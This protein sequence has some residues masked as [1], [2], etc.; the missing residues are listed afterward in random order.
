MIIYVNYVQAGSHMCVLGEAHVEG[1]A[2]I[3]INYYVA[4]FEAYT[5]NYLIY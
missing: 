1:R 5:G 2:L 3:Y 4:V